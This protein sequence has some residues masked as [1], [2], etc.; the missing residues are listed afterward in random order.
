MQTQRLS[1]KQVRRKRAPN[2]VQ[3]NIASIGLREYLDHV[4]STGR[5]HNLC[6]AP[7]I[8]FSQEGSLQKGKWPFE[9]GIKSSDCWCS[10]DGDGF[11]VRGSNYLRDRKKVPAGQ[12]LAE[13]VAV[14]W[15]VDYQRIDDICSRPAGTCQRYILVVDSFAVFNF[16]YN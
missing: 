9:A 2:L 10:P 11:R 15:F 16:E 6:T 3:D 14:D 7:G 4:P 5:G 13:L 12:P 8:N 1:D